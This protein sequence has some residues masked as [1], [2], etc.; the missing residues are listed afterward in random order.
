MIHPVTTGSVV[1]PTFGKVGQ[2]KRHRPLQEGA[3][4]HYL[5]VL[6][7]VRY[8]VPSGLVTGLTLDVGA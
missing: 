5:L 8:R 3:W 7:S 2:A 4:I 1:S 6:L